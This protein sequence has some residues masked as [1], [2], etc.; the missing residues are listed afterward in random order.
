MAH[1]E[2]D[3]GKSRDVR[4]TF[5]HE[6]LV[7]HR[8]YETASILNDFLVSFWFLIGSVMFFYPAWVYTGTW[9][10]VVGSAQLLVRPCLRLAHNIHLRRLPGSSWEM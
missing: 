7:I 3:N 9:L 4:V 6:Q 5:G 8:R 2:I 10:F 1:I